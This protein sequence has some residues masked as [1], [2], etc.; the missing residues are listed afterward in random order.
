MPS[1]ASA[2][3]TTGYDLSMDGSLEIVV[4][5][6]PEA[7]AEEAAATIARV[8]A[9]AVAAR[10]RFTLVLSGGETP[11]ATYAC[12][13]APAF[14]ERIR[15]D[16]T[17]IFFG[18]ERGVAAD[19]RDSNYGMARTVLLDRVAVSPARV[20]RIRGDA[21]DPEAAALDYAQTMSRELGLRRGEWPRFDLVLLGLGVDGHIASLFPGSPAA[22]E[23]FRPIVAVHAAAAAIPQRFTLTLPVLNAAA[24]VIFLVAGPEK[25][26]IVKGVLQDHAPV[27]ATMVRPPDGRLLWLL[28]RAAASLLPAAGAA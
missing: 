1:Y 11:R 21:D 22:R 5:D 17:S 15:W 3:S 9:E 18:D 10:D 2:A 24:H 25:A 27:P 16:R 19:H 7:L 8:A 20:F 23:V 12:L 6:S 28:D 26:K 4:L 14:R 13:A